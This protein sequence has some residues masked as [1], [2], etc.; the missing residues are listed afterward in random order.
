MAIFMVRYTHKKNSGG[1]SFVGERE[2]SKEA[3]PLQLQ[4]G[5]TLGR[6]GVNFLSPS[7]R[8]AKINGSRSPSI[9]VP[10]STSTIPE[11]VAI[12]TRNATP[13]VM[14]VF[15]SHHG[16]VVACSIV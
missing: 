4:R 3:S 14:I 11:A 10:V 16:F 13:D 5:A 8:N 7:R 12:A 9:F 2:A 6:Y 1:G 15:E